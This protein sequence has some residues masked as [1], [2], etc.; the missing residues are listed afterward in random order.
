MATR[1]SSV[2]ILCAIVLYYSVSAVSF[3]GNKGEGNGL[4]FSDLE[5]TRNRL[6]NE[7]QAKG[8]KDVPVV[9]REGLLKHLNVA[10]L[11][12]HA[13]LL[14]G[15]HDISQE[16]LDQFLGL[17]R[18]KSVSIHAIHHGVASRSKRSLPTG[19]ALYQ[20]L[21]MMSG[22][23]VVNAGKGTIGSVVDIIKDAINTA[24]VSLMKF[25]FPTSGSSTVGIPVDSQLMELS[26]TI[27]GTTAAPACQL[28][29]PDGTVEVF[30]VG[31][32]AEKVTLASSKLEKLKIKQ[33]VNGMW[34]LER[35]SADDWEVTVDGQSTFTFTYDFIETNP[36]T[37][38]T[39]HVTGRPIA[40]ENSTIAINLSDIQ[41]ITSVSEVIFQNQDGDRISAHALWQGLGKGAKSFKATTVLPSQPFRIQIEGVDN[42][43]STFYRLYTQLVYVVTVEFDVSVSRS[44]IYLSEKLPVTF[45]ITN[46]ATTTMNYEVMISDDVGFVTKVTKN[47][48]MAAGSSTTDT[49]DV[50]AGVVK[51]I[52]STV[53]LNAQEVGGSGIVYQFVTRRFTT[54]EKLVVVTDSYPPTCNITALTRLCKREEQD[55]CYCH[56]Y[57]WTLE[58]EVAEETGLQFILAEFAGNSSSFVHDNFTQGDNGTFKVKYSSNCCF[59]KVFINVADMYGNLGQCVVDFTLVNIPDTCMPTT[60][61]TTP[62]SSGLSTPTMVGITLG[63]V[64]FV[65]IIATVVTSVVMKNLTGTTAKVG[66][67]MARKDGETDSGSE[68]VKAR[69]LPAPK[70]AEA[71]VGKEV[72]PGQAAY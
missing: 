48:N 24:P 10:V 51:G 22:G 7:L 2:V 58:A 44:N 30:A 42:V 28:K 53:T 17:S 36:L 23:S 1:F 20:L 19:N 59:P 47:Y 60:T 16:E 62:P 39:Y 8:I 55:P 54:T 18:E 64:I 41:N 49:F 45:T 13:I 4:L 6:L 33:P 57:N 65:V 21:A 14:L 15:Y 9:T 46:K 67:E 34:T 63:S 40:G 69:S 56:H 52:T 61:V 31:T 72:L 35:T 29:R 71:W 11:Q 26:I 12:S 32:N 27:Q 43:G 70:P 66:T 68:Q 3:Q 37:G 5:D 50:T 25:T 38:L